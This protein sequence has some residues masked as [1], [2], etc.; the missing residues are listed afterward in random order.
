VLAVSAF[1]DRQDAIIELREDIED[2][3]S[4]EPEPG[5]RRRNWEIDIRDLYIDLIERF[6]D[7]QPPVMHNTD[8]ELVLPQNVLFDVDDA[9]AAFTGLVQAGLA[10]DDAQVERATDGRLERAQLAWTKTG[11]RLHSSWENTILG[12]IEITDTRL[13]AHMNSNERA[14]AFREVVAQALGAGARL[15]RRRS[16]RRR[17]TAGRARAP[18]R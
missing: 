9:D 16:R 15:R 10:T 11:N 8:G 14:R 17:R 2:D 13:V 12:S 6:I 7:P 1:A 18:G 3:E 4:A 5:D